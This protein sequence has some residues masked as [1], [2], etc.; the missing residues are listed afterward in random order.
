M[1]HLN[2]F[3]QAVP[4]APIWFILFGTAMLVTA[5]F[6]ILLVLVQRGRGGGLAGAF[7]GMGGQSAFGA[8]AGDTFTKVTIYASTF[9]ILLCMA[10]LAILNPKPPAEAEAPAGINNPAEMAPADGMGTGGGAVDG[11]T[12]TDGTSTDG[13]ATDAADADGTAAG[14]ATGAGDDGTGA[15]GGEAAEGPDTT[16]E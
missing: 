3:A 13:A 11:E 16:N 5:I 15:V 14:D 10:A 2:F 6:L 1:S 8:K 4:V 12:A 9:W 7:G